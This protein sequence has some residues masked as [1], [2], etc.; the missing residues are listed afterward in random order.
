[1]SGKPDIA[2]CGVT[3][4]ITGSVAVTIVWPNEGVQSTAYDGESFEEALEIAFDEAE[5][6]GLDLS[7][8]L[9]GAERWSVDVR[10]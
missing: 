8:K 6:A 4:V 9:P 10:P 7:I 5:R 2:A 3:I 1:M